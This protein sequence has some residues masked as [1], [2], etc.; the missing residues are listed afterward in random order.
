[1]FSPPPKQLEEQSGQMPPP[2]FLCTAF[3]NSCLPQ[4]FATYC[5]QNSL[6]IVPPKQS[7]CSHDNTTGILL[8]IGHA[9]R[10]WTSASLGVGRRHMQ[11]HC[12]R[13]QQSQRAHIQHAPI[14]A[15]SCFIGADNTT[16]ILSHLEIV[17]GSCYQLQV[18]QNKLAG[19][20]AWPNLTTTEK[21]LCKSFSVENESHKRFCQTTY[22]QTKKHHQ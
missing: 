4:L 6:W 10:G 22:F 1:M 12:F 8:K 9:K 3:S 16:G 18:A 19:Q 20:R 7:Y 5:L 13:A 21:L 15:I 17:P 14:L 2:T 11:I